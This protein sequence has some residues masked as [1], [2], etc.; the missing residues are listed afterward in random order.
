[1]AFRDLDRAILIP[2]LNY[3]LVSDLFDEFSRINSCL[4]S[5]AYFFTV[6]PTQSR[7]LPPILNDKRPLCNGLRLT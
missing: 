4:Q 6:T 1:M 5:F 2:L 7:S 3:R